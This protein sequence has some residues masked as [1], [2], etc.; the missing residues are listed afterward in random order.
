MSS[1]RIYVSIL[2]TPSKGSYLT[3]FNRMVFPCFRK[4]YVLR[5][6]LCTT[7]IFIS[8]VYTECRILPAIPVDLLV[9]SKLL[10]SRTLRRGILDVQSN[11]PRFI[12]ESRFSRPE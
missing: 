5:G 2:S 3:G 10:P 6:L 8:F 11:M 4:T 1:S 12:S 9:Y 7:R